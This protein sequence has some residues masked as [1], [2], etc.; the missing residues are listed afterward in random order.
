MG[1]DDNLTIAFE[2]C[3]QNIPDITLEQCPHFINNPDI[4]T[5]LDPRKK[6]FTISQKFPNHKIKDPSQQ[7][8]PL[9]IHDPSTV[10]HWGNES[11]MMRIF[12]KLSLA[13]NI[14]SPHYYK[15]KNRK[16]WEI[17]ISQPRGMASRVQWKLIH[18]L[19]HL[20]NDMPRWKIEW[21]CRVFLKL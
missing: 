9:W 4:I 20:W 8:K 17:I 18:S 2:Q 11:I 3:L 1:T 15:R 5:H 12:T 10:T 13:L 6:S 14:N 7:T 16:S 21:Y 19:I